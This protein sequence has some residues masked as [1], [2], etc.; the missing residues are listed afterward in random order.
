MTTTTNDYAIKPLPSEHGFLTTVFLEEF[1]ECRN[2]FDRMGIPSFMVQSVCTASVRESI[3]TIF[4]TQFR[5]HRPGKMVDDLRH[6]GHPNLP[7]SNKLVSFTARTGKDQKQFLVAVRCDAWAKDVESVNVNTVLHAYGHYIEEKVRDEHMKS[8]LLAVNNSLW[9]AVEWCLR[10]NVHNF[11]EKELILIAKDI[12][13]WVNALWL[14]W[15]FS[16]DAKQALVEM[17][18]DLVHKG[19]LGRLF[20]RDEIPKIEDLFTSRMAAEREFKKAF[21]QTTFDSFLK[22]DSERYRCMQ[23]DHASSLLLR[24]LHN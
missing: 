13:A 22:M 2:L 23:I 17:V 14:Y 15:I 1:P 12:A 3:A 11:S 5:I 16:V 7:P 4:D 21:H 18:A 10:N 19:H 20:V 8:G 6:E 24:S 9:T